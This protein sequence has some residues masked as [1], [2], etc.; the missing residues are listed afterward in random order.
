MSAQTEICTLP[1]SVWSVRSQWSH[2]PRGVGDG[3][4]HALTGHGPHPSGRER[5]GF[6][7]G[8]PVTSQDGVSQPR[9]SEGG[10]LHA[11]QAG[12]CGT[13]AHHR[14]QAVRQK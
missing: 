14:G 3:V 1:G 13:T 11:V 2:H 4:V 8:R 7:S 10:L 9:S 5:S 6:H 12:S